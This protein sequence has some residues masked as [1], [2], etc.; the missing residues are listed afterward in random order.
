M[1]VHF[2]VYRTTDGEIIRSGTCAKTV[3]ARQAS[4][5]EAVLVTTDLVAPEGYAIHEGKVVPRAKSVLPMTYAQKRRAEYPPLADFADA[6]YWAAQGDPSMLE[7]YNEKVAAVKTRY[8][9]P[10]NS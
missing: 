2:V 8:P 10:S 7:A 3:V 4:T 5:G 6:M 1:N 9:K